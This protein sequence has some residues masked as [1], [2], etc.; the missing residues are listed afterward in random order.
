MDL[1]KNYVDPCL[2]YTIYIHAITSYSLKL[3]EV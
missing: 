3:G 1:F 2:K